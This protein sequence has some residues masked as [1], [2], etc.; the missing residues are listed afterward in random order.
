MRYLLFLLVLVFSSVAMAQHSAALFFSYCLGVV[1]MDQTR[2]STLPL[3]KACARDEEKADCELR[4]AE[5]ARNRVDRAF[6]VTRFR[7]L[8]LLTTEGVSAGAV[9]AM[10]EFGRED[11]VT[12]WDATLERLG[13]R[14]P[15]SSALWEECSKHPACQLTRRC[16]DPSRWPI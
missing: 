13:C 8:G 2:D 12:C 7:Q 1:E 5:R 15:I 10:R 4:L 3:A 14:Y 11:N 6:L 16:Y 9:S